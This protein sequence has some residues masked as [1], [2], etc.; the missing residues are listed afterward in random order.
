[1]TRFDEKRKRIYEKLVRNY[2]GER[3]NVCRWW[4]EGWKLNGDENLT[5]NI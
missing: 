1:M 4:M 2:D 5:K 3:V